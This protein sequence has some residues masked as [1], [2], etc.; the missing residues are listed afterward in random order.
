M[1]YINEENKIEKE[2]T[3]MNNKK[4]KD[5]IMN[6]NVLLNI[7]ENKISQINTKELI[8]FVDPDIKSLYIVDQ[9]KK[10]N[11]LIEH[12]IKTVKNLNTKQNEMLEEKENSDYSFLFKPAK[13][14][15]K[16]TAI[17]KKQ[18]RTK[19]IQIK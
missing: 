13:L 1:N 9:I 8:S 11:N 2:Y 19:I 3:Y 16:N 6:H 14:L 7:I 12:E 17:K 10:Y 15:Y 4:S 5:I 18:L